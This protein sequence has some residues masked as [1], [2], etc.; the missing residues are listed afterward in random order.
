MWTID[1]YDQSVLCIGRYHRG[2]KVLGIFNF[3]EHDK[4]AWIN[5]EDGMYLNMLNG[6]KME[7]RG[8]DVPGYGFYWLM[9]D[10]K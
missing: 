7:A 4:T 10:N 6:Q 1:T 3:S 9:L 5:E 8:V 2:V